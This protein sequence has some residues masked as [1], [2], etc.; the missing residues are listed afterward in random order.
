VR[1][2]KNRIYGAALIMRVFRNVYL[3]FFDELQLRHMA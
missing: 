2:R 3:S 1:V